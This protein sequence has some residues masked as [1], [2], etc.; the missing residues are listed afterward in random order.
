[1]TLITCFMWPLG[2]LRH[3]QLAFVGHISFLDLCWPGTY[4]QSCLLNEQSSGRI[5]WCL[6]SSLSLSSSPLLLVQ[7]HS[8]LSCTVWLL[9]GLWSLRN[10]VTL[11]RAPCFKRE[12]SFLQ[13]HCTPMFTFPSKFNTDSGAEPN[14]LYSEQL[15]H[16]LLPPGCLFFQAAQKD[17]LVLG[18]PPCVWTWNQTWCTD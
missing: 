4:R 3:V 10:G 8:S 14:K 18:I 12:D 5:H 17:A 15:P 16:P 11:D 1:M 6:F 7:P 9:G 2:S 13:A